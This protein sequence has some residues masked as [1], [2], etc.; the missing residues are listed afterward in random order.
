MALASI[1][2]HRWFCRLGCLAPLLLAGCGSN[3]NLAGTE[4]RAVECAPYARALTGLA[5]DGEA[6]QWWDEADGRYARSQIP[7]VGAALVFRR[8]WQLPSGHVAVVD[9]VLSTRE[10]LVNQANWIHHRISHDDEVRDVSVENDWTLVRVWWRPTAS[11][12]LNLYPTYGF[13]GPADAAWAGAPAR[14]KRSLQDGGTS[15]VCAVSWLK[16]DG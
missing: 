7:A 5:L 14:P 13:V 3:P 6:Y 9:K 16:T 11:L 15:A 10:I 1:A 8:S 12:G 2:L 4:P